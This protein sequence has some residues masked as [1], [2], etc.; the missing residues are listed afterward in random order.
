MNYGSLL[1]GAGSLYSGISSY[2]SSFETASLLREQGALARQDY[3]RQAALVSDKGY[4]FRAQQT[5]AYV[6]SGVE[7]SGTPLLVLKETL[8]K[9]RVQ[10]DA[11]QTTGANIQTLYG[12]K[13]S[14][15]KKEGRA[16][17]ISGLLSAGGSFINAAS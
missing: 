4:R 17:L 10:A 16:S 14:I 7:I 15:V 3:D 5:M 11:L 12:K 8:V 1:S 6:S 9:S 13:A 2:M